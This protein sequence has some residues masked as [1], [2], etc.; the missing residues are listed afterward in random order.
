L[1]CLFS[2]YTVSSSCFTREKFINVNKFILNCKGKIFYDESNPINNFISGSGSGTVISYGSGST[3]HKVTVPTVPVPVPQRKKSELQQPN[4][5]HFLL[6]ELP[7]RNR[8]ERLGAGASQLRCAE[9]PVRLV[10]R[11][12]HLQAC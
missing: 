12:R 1:F 8:S 10:D 5:N 3:C 4:C 7:P 6:K 2:F 9:E 11:W